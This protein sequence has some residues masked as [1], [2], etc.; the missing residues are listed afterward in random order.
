MS[1]NKYYR[2]YL[3]YNNEMMN[4]SNQRDIPLNFYYYHRVIATEIN[5]NIFYSVSPLV[6]NFKVKSTI[7]ETF[8]EYPYLKQRTL[9]R[10]SLD[11]PYHLVDSLAK[12]W[13]ADDLESSFTIQSESEKNITRSRYEDILKEGRRFR[14]KI[15][16]VTAA[17]GTITNI[18]YGGGNIAVYTNPKYRQKGYG[19]MVVSSCVKWC[20]DHEIIPIYL[21]DCDNTASINLAKSLGFKVFSK[22][23]ILS[24]EVR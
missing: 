24:E 3:E 22:E 8:N 5:D 4:Q 16:N 20:F 14:I 1:L 6:N 17:I 12:V 10:M 2:K 18:D 15:N 21:V 11:G 7:I 23:Y 13:T 19:K 9:F